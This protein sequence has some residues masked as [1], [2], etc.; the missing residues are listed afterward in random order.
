[1]LREF[2][3]ALFPGLG[4]LVD[5]P[6]LMSDL[7]TITN[8][9]PWTNL[10]EFVHLSTVLTPALIQPKNMDQMS[11]LQKE[12]EHVYEA[13]RP[14]LEEL[15]IKDWPGYPESDVRDF[16]LLLTR[17]MNRLDR[18]IP[19]DILGPLSGEDSDEEPT[20]EFDDSPPSFF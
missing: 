15:V 9:A 13:I 10:K 16:R 11:G 7:N 5:H 18:T 1:M 17:W 8:K 12:I 14:F 4:F 3:A 6:D 20:A 2:L 19:V